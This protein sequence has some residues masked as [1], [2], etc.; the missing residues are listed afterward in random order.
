MSTA[1]DEPLLLAP[2]F[3]WVRPCHRILRK[4]LP[5]NAGLHFPTASVQSHPSSSCPFEDGR[6]GDVRVKDCLGRPEESCRVFAGESRPARARVPLPL[7][8]I[9]REPPSCE[10]SVP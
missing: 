2:A 10:T 1:R 7:L 5:M 9:P 8:Q 6:T 3:R 4:S